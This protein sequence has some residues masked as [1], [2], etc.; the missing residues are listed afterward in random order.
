VVGW[1][2]DRRSARMNNEKVHIR[3]FASEWE[4]TCAACGYT[5][6][7][8]RAIARG[9]VRGMSSVSLRSAGAR[10]R[11]GGS[12]SF[13]ATRG[14]IE[15]RAEQIEGFRKCAKCGADEFTQR[16]SPRS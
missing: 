16:P 5:W 2:F 4:R 6:R 10:P 1:S 15:T 7:V 13:A 3:L 12:G 14:I 8:P 9:G 11:A